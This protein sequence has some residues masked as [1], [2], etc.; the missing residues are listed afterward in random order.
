[1][2]EIKDSKQITPLIE[3]STSQIKEYVH[4]MKDFLSENQTESLLH[5]NQE[6]TKSITLLK[7][8]ALLHT[9]Q[10]QYLE[11]DQIYSKAHPLYIYQ[12]IINLLSN[13]IEA[14]KESS[15]KKVIIILKKQNNSYCIECKDFGCGISKEISSHIGIHHISSKSSSRGFGLYSVHHIVKHILGGKLSIQSEPDNG[16]LFSCILPIR[17]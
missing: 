9:V 15:I 6:I 5:I 7:H 16:S 8:Q 13:A 10:I 3:H 4:I 14:S 1:M 17:K 11:F 2:P 12:I